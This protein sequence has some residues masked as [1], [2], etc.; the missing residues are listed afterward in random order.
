M[1]SKIMLSGSN[2]LILDGP[3]NHLDLESIT[4]VNEGLQRFKGTVIFTCHDHELIQTVANRIIELGEDGGVK[5]DNH[6]TY[7][8]YIAATKA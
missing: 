4:A 5:Y 7:D 2:I 1:F 3:T 8:E 6:I